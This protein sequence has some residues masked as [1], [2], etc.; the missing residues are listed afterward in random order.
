MALSPGSFRGLDA[1][2]SRIPELIERQILNRIEIL[3]EALQAILR[4]REV[5]DVVSYRP[6]GGKESL[7]GL[8]AFMAFQ[9][10]SLLRDSI[11]CS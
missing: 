1:Q 8:R 11:H 10:P 4:Q 3:A 5:L 7:L 9:V 6:I 2:G